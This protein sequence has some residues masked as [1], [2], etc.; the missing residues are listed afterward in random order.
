M[1]Q[2]YA[3]K[4]SRSALSPKRSTSAYWAQPCSRAAFPGSEIFSIVLAY[5]P[6][7]HNSVDAAKANSASVDLPEINSVVATY[8]CSFAEAARYSK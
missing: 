5:R 6:P 2:K 4:L 1:Q 8:E 7:N 3:L